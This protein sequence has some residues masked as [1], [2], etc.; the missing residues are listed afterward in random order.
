MKSWHLAIGAVLFGAA[1]ALFHVLAI[2]AVALTA[3]WGW[4]AHLERR[5]SVKVLSDI[6]NKLAVEFSHLVKTGQEWERRLRALEV[7]IVPESQK[8]FGP[9]R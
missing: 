4:A 7:K 6:H 2:P 3:A 9:K 1:S 8:Q 5:E